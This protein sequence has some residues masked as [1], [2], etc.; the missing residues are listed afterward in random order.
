MSFVSVAPAPPTLFPVFTAG[1]VLAAS[2][3]GLQM[4]SI[5]ALI[6]SFGLSLKRGHQPAAFREPP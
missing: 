5:V 3:E 2:G 1:A 4:A 6:V